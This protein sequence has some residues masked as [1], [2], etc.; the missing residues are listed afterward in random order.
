MDLELINFWLRRHLLY[1]R[2]D[3]LYTEL[4]A[5][6]DDPLHSYKLFLSNDK[7]KIL[8][9]FGY[10]IEVEYDNLKEINLFEYLCT[11]KKLDNDYIAYCGFKGPFAKNKQHKKLN[12]YLVKKSFEHKNNFPRDDTLQKEAII[13]FNVNM[14]IYKFQYDLMNQIFDKKIKLPQHSYEKL[15]NFLLLHGIDNFMKWSDEELLDKWNKYKNVDWKI[16][17][18]LR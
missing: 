14:K 6:N 18:I 10:N 3:S 13:F 17:D 11:S 12:D 16:L 1:I 8:E 9:F 4:N 7:R 2:N 5:Y 15:S